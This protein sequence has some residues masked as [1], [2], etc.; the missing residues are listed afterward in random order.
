MLHLL[1]DL[2]FA[3]RKLAKAPGFTTVAVLTLAIGI[4][5]TTAIFSVANAVLLRP[6]PG[7]TG[8]DRLVAVY[9]SDFSSGPYGTSSYPDYL[10]YR[11]QVTAFSGLAAFAGF[12][13]QVNFSAGGEAER[14]GIQ[15]ASGNYFDV[16]GVDAAAGRTLRPAD[17]EAPGAGAVAVL[18]HAAWRQRFGTDPGVIGRTIRLNGRAFTVVGVAPRD[19]HGT[20]L[21]AVPEAWIPTSMA[22]L[23]FG[24]ADVLERRGSRWMGMVGRLAPGATIEQAA[25]QIRT[26]AAQLAIAWPD[27]N[28]GTLQA[29]DEARPMTLLPTS[30]AMID[31][32]ARETV[33][34]VAWLLGAAA[35]LVLLIACAN[36]ANL[37]LARAAGRGG[38]IALRFSLGAARGRV[39]RQLLTESLLLGIVGGAAGLA[40]ALSLAGLFLDSGFVIDLVAAEAVPVSLL[41]FGVL[42]FAFLVS[43][44]ASVAFG[45]APALQASRTALV[46]VLKE[47]GSRAAAGGGLSR[48][49]SALVVGQVAFALVLLVG[50]GLFVESLQ[51]TLSVQ[52]GFTLQRA[53]IASLDLRSSGYGAA[54]GL[55]LFDALKERT[56]SQPQVTSTAL[57]VLV[58]VNASGMRRRA[59]VD[60][61]LPQPSEDMEINFNLVGRDYFRTMGIELLRGRGF[62]ESDREG[63]PRVA[64][65]NETFAQRYFGGA[66]PVGRTFRYG[67]ADG[68]PVRIVGMV[69][70]GKYRSLHEPSL[71]YIYEP[72]SQNYSPFVSLVVAT[73][74]EPTDMV[75]L[76]R[77]ELRQL[78][79]NLPLFGVRTLQEHLGALVG[80]ERA[81]SRLVTAF[82]VV[83]LLLATLGI[84]G[85]MSF[86]VAQRTRE[87]GTRMAL[88]ARAG[89]VLRLVMG[90]GAMLALVGLM[91]GFAAALGASRALASQLYGVSVM[92][93]AI[94]GV[95]AAILAIAALVACYIPARRATRVDPVRSLR[96]E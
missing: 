62:L 55:A 54:E 39:V 78:D 4:G 69:R 27:T 64:V 13:R 95:V 16:L 44:A 30:E 76:L 18:S 82:G 20:E 66:D 1:N 34:R 41:D 42:G 43:V 6:L 11:D 91:V 83:A 3:I 46:S 48:T 81:V 15:L 90:R 73:A 49:R 21:A 12:T 37:Q 89:S 94:F 58:P 71:P 87:I 36:L 72:L 56:E 26:I 57:A 47:S 63:A 38:E 33:V 7:V 25:A 80:S 14:I 88:G 29:P 67:G 35:L 32:G 23:V 96:E 10:D 2:R 70:D 53:L 93:P 65:V 31:P 86:L 59:D 52:R 22:E 61:Y 17:A 75:P 50:A 5:A 24:S 68:D 79:A 8:P 84:Y 40:L 45:L 92:E 85:V 51:Q 60:G 74:G 77:A 28:L 19:F 9:T